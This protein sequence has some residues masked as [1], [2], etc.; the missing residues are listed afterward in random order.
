M[1]LWK[2]DNAKNEGIYTCTACG[3][4]YDTSGPCPKCGAKINTASVRQEVF[5]TTTNLGNSQ[6]GI[7]EEKIDGISKDIWNLGLQHSLLNVLEYLMGLLLQRHKDQVS[8]IYLASRF[9]AKDSGLELG[10]AMFDMDLERAK[11]APYDILY[12]S[13]EDSR[14][15]KV[16]DHLLTA[17]IDP[18]T[19]NAGPCLAKVTNL[20]NNGDIGI[21]DLFV[22]T[23]PGQIIHYNQILGIL[24]TR[25]EFGTEMWFKLQRDTSWIES[26][27]R[28][29]LEEH[30]DV[31]KVNEIRR[32][33]EVLE[34]H[35]S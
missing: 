35:R 21:I 11:F 1:I 4:R 24:V 18:G 29:L 26:S 23:N 28:S 30:T 3:F 31:A 13:H 12:F 5:Q 22:P 27:L 17:V 33:L 9:M 32:R 14:N 8:Q 34:A 6:V 19:M 7:P 20:G 10:Y 25:V 16:G 15:I 2:R